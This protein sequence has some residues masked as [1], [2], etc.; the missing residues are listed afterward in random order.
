MIRS[1]TKMGT[2]FLQYDKNPGQVNPVLVKIPKFG[3]ANICQ[4]AHLSVGAAI[5]DFCLNIWRDGLK[6]KQYICFDNKI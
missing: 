2:F 4:A 6:L 3:P 1:D 5:K